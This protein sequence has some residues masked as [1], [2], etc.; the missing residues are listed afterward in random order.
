MGQA[1][2]GDL[3]WFIL[4]SSSCP[5]WNFQQILNFLLMQEGILG[6]W[7][8][9]GDEGTI[10]ICITLLFFICIRNS[11][12][13]SYVLDNFLIFFLNGKCVFASK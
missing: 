6:W 7:L 12:I 5:L 9:E 2:D 13:S 4:Y 11:Y 8:T 10:D 1:K 3:M